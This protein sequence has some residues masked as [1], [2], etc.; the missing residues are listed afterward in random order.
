MTRQTILTLTVA[1]ACSACGEPDEVD[2]GSARIALT[3]APPGVGC[4]AIVAQGTRTLRRSIDVTAGV[5]TRFDMTGL[6]TGVVSLTGNA[7]DTACSRV[8]ASAS[9]SWI[10]DVVTVRITPG[11][12]ANVALLMRR[13][14]KA[15]VGVDWGS[16][17]P[18][19]TAY[20]PFGYESGTSV[21]DEIGGIG[22]SAGWTAGGA[23]ASVHDNFI[24]ES[25]SLVYPRLAVSGGHVHSGAQMSISGVSRPLAQPM[26]QDGTTRYLS[27]LVQPEGALGEGI[28]SGFFGLALGAA[29]SA[30]FIGKPGGG[31]LDVFVVEEL[32]GAGQVPSTSSTVLGQVTLFVVKAEFGDPTDRFTLYVN[33]QVGAAE[34]ATGI[35][36]QDRGFGE[37][38][39]VLLYSSGAFSL[40]EIRVGDTFASV[41]PVAP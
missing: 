16:E 32:G 11:G 23:S 35:V 14:G 30:L 36:K 41:T 28:F 1:L 27:F 22:F 2:T 9:P 38:G 6:P 34:P 33:P 21:P 40:D 39:S 17:P 7:F 25:G 13:N 5:S 31:Q 37:M 20:E 15:S 12:V 3:Q 26:G 24:V 10:S 29:E 19:P 4:V 18:Q 8:A